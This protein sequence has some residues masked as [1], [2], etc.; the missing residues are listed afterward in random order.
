MIRIQILDTFV[1]LT[2]LTIDNNNVHFYMNQT[3]DMYPNKR[4]RAIDEDDRVVDIL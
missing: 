4:V 3:K 2:V 1:W